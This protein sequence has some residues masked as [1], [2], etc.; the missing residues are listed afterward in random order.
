MAYSDFTSLS[1]VRQT[2]GLEIQ[3]EAHLFAQA[4]V[5]PAS[6]RLTEMLAENTDLAAAIATEKA[7]SELLITPILLEVRRICQ[8]QVGFFSGVEF[9]VEASLG[10]NGACDYLLTASANQSLITAP[11]LTLVEAK[12]DLL[13]NGLGQCAAQMYA[14]WLFNEREG[15]PQAIV[16]GAV[17]TGTTWKFLTLQNTRLMIDLREYYI[18]QIE[19]ILGIL[20]NSLQSHITAMV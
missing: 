3:D 14:A 19:H 2:L 10:L 9:S 6:Q 15:T 16:H 11:V 5:I 8:N 18:N 17:S 20:V 1:K 13:K 12:N 7:K 4:Q